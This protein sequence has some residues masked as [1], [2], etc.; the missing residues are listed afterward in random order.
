MADPLSVT[1]SIL[2]ILGAG[3]AVG[4]GLRKLL[5]LKRAPDILLALNNEIADL[6]CVIQTVNEVLR[7]HK[8]IEESSVGRVSQSLDNIKRTLMTFESFVAYELTVVEDNDN[9]T[10]LDKSSWLLAEPKVKKLKNQIQVDKA[11]L[12]LASSL[13]TQYCLFLR[14]YLPLS[15]N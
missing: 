12:C 14:S 9:H 7:Q 8:A 2:A 4:K 10:R 11:D 6:H 1:A 5:K 15:F 3:G 13:F